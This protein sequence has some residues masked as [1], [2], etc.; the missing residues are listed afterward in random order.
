MIQP[1]TGKGGKDYIRVT[2]IR[3]MGATREISSETK[4]A[5]EEIVLNHL[6]THKKPPRKV[7]VQRIQH[8]YLLLNLPKTGLSVAD[9]DEG[10]IHIGTQYCFNHDQPRCKECPINFLCEGYQFNRHLIENYRT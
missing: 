10:L 7:E 9:F 6:M 8:A 5:Y 3:G 1:G 2:N 4:S